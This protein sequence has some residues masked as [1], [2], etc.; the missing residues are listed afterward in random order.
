MPAVMVAVAALTGG[1]LLRVAVRVFLGRGRPAPEDRHSAAAGGEEP[2]EGA[3]P[4]ASTAVLVWG[5]GA[6]PAAA[7]PAWGGG[8]GGVGAGGAGGGGGGGGPRGGR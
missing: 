7:G 6:A 2:D 3:E 8:P 5:P 1:A 4:V